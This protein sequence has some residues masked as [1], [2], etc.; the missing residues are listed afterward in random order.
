MSSQ[1]M[2]RLIEEFPDVAKGDKLHLYRLKKFFK[3]LKQSDAKIIVNDKAEKAVKTYSAN[4]QQGE[5]RFFK[6]IA[7]VFDIEDNYASKYINGTL[8][9]KKIITNMDRID[10]IGAILD[11]ITMHYGSYIASEELKYIPFRNLNFGFYSSNNF[12]KSGSEVDKKRR[13][14]EN[15]FSVDLWGELG[16][17]RFLY[18]FISKKI[19]GFTTL[20]L[21]SN[22][23]ENHKMFHDHMNEICSSFT[24]GEKGRLH[25]VEIHHELLNLLKS[26]L[27]S[28]ES[29]E[30]QK[31]LLPGYVDL[32]IICN[33]KQCL[34]SIERKYD[35]EEKFKLESNSFSVSQT[36]EYRYEIVAFLKRMN[37][38]ASEWST[39]DQALLIFCNFEMKAVDEVIKRLMFECKKNIRFTLFTSNSHNATRNQLPD[40]TFIQIATALVNYHTNDPLDELFQIKANSV[41][42][43]PLRA[44]AD[45][46]GVEHFYSESDY[47]RALHYTVGK[48]LKNRIIEDIH[49]NIAPFT[50][51]F[52]QDTP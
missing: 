47:Y 29:F 27:T 36:I 44:V 25:E 26:Y 10:D 16:H 17:D 45:Q 20:F 22:E 40:L 34:R 37:K 9:V 38:P 18:N 11:N 31:G 35:T 1:N 48:Y 5:E 42:Q 28:L 15:K 33:K 49:G 41:L 52:D 3:Y 24:E 4:P 51:A 32:S 23:I 46:Y 8:S 14:E 12:F 19:R 7:K 30:S 50:Y 43:K 6:L 2:G 39:K 13:I 21:G